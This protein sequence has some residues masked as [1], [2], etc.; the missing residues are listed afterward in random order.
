[1]LYHYLQ[2]HYK[3]E[4]WACF[5]LNGFNLVFFVVTMFLFPF[6][7]YKKHRAAWN[8]YKMKFTYQALGLLV[9]LLTNETINLVTI[10][11]GKLGKSCKSC[12]P[13]IIY[14]K[15]QVVQQIALFIFILCK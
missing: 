12:A 1:M 11:A 13:D 6:T 9:V 3:F 10:D 15:L 8:D 5:G 14:F 2:G 7:A 4:S